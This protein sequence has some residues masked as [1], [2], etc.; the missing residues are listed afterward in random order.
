[1]NINEA[2][3]AD[4]MDSIPLFTQVLTRI[5]CGTPRQRAALTDNGLVTLRGLEIHTKTSLTA[6]FKRISDD[7]R[8][9]TAAQRV[10]INDKIQRGMQGIRFHLVERKACDATLTQVQID[11][12]TAA[13]LDRYITL[14][15]DAEVEDANAKD[16]AAQGDLVIPKLESESWQ[17]WKDMM[18]EKLKR[19]RGHNGLPLEYVTREDDTGDYDTQF[20]NREA[21]RLACTRHA[22]TEFSKDNDAVYSILMEATK[23]TE[24]ETIVAR[25]HKGTGTR[26]G[27]AAYKLL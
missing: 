10:V 21:R 18:D 22:G 20:E 4:P 3:V 11:G 6:L 25:F 14:M 27:R 8:G 26:D 12:I 24:G 15:V 17:E 5:G 7:N 19:K 1:M 16:R 23:G 2:V 9:H 13:S